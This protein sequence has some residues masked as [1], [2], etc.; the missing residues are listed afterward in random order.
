MTGRRSEVKK[1]S[2]RGVLAS[3]TAAFLLLAWSQP[4]LAYIKAPP[5]TLGGMCLETD[6]IAVL[7]VEKVNADRGVIFFKHVEQLK[8]SHD[9][10]VLRHVIKPESKGTKLILD[11]VAEGKTAVMFYFTGGNDRGHVYIDD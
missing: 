11:L 10:S 7:K 6:Q 5:Q 3:W 1:G 8:G 9:G 2:L 4:A